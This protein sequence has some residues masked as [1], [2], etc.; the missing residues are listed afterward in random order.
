[1]V[2]NQKRLSFCLKWVCNISFE[3]MKKQL[4]YLVTIALL[5]SL[6]A[7]SQGDANVISANPR[8]NDNS[9]SNSESAS[10][11]SSSPDNPKDSP[12]SAGDKVLKLNLTKKIMTEGIDF[13]DGCQP[14]VSYFDGF[15]Y[16][17]L[18]ADDTTFTITKGDQTYGAGDPLEAGDYK[19]VASYLDGA[20]K[21]SSSFKVNGRSSTV[22]AKEGAGYYKAG[23]FSSYSLMNHP[24]ISSSRRRPLSS[25]GEQKMSGRSGLL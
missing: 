6:G 2:V 8:G 4:L 25:I 23:D 10:S 24:S 20:F 9:S 11:D 16:I 14:V 22:I 1:L 3:K 5:A 15:D 19:V 17:D 18:K 13:Y 21:D 12:T 7:C